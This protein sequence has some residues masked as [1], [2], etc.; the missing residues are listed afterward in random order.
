MGAHHAFN[1]EEHKDHIL[2]ILFKGTD[3][4]SAEKNLK[5]LETTRRFVPFM[6]IVLGL[7][8]L[9]NGRAQSGAGYQDTL[10]LGDA[11][12]GNYTAQLCAISIYCYITFF[13]R[14]V[15]LLTKGFVLVAIAAVGYS[16]M[17]MG[18]RNGLLS[19]GLVSLI[20]FG[21]NMLGK[22]LGYK[23]MWAIF[24]IIINE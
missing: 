15:S 4:L 12:H 16:I 14:R 10:Q 1:N 17:Q 18:S 3:K 20:G 7:N 22:S 19:F 9:L 13:M 21:I 23:F 2:S 5:T 24:N 6:L 8:L 11:H